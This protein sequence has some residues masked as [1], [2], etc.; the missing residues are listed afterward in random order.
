LALRRER[1]RI[2]SRTQA[3]VAWIHHGLR[4]HAAET[5]EAETLVLT[6]VRGALGERTSHTPRGDCVVRSAGPQTTGFHRCLKRASVVPLGRFD[7]PLRHVPP[8]FCSF[9][10]PQDRE[11]AMNSPPRVTIYHNPACGTSRNTLALI[12]NAGVEP[13]IIEYL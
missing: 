1:L 13:E 2:D 3:L 9:M 8:L 4:T 12:R 10:F 5:L 7:A 11:Q 6:L